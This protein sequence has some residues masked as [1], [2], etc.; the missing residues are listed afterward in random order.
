MECLDSDVMVYSVVYV[1]VT[2][3]LTLVWVSAICMCYC[4]MYVSL[5]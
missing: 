4:Q 5:K 2:V 1:G 3:K